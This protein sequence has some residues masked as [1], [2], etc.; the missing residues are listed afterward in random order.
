MI[1]C[2]S[3]PDFEVKCL[4][5]YRHSLH[6]EYVSLKP[7]CEKSCLKNPNER[8]RVHLFIW[9]RHKNCLIKTF[10]R[11][12]QWDKTSVKEKRVQHTPHDNITWIICFKHIKSFN[13]TLIEV[14]YNQ[15]YYIH[16]KFHALSHTN[17]IETCDYIN[18]MIICL[19]IQVFVKF[20]M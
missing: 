13:V 11:K 3:A 7:Y 4:L 8:K 2:G 12:T 9:I 6:K 17:E 19:L 20:I 16:P 5:G 18:H 15:I 10:G 14:G 1:P